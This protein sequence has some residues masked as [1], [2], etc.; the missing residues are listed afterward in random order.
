MKRCLACKSNIV[1]FDHTDP[2][3]KKYLS[4]YGKI[5]TRKETRLCAR[6]QRNLSRAIKRARTLALLPYT[7]R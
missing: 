2:A 6:H 4:N 7:N 1:D 5:K 3:L